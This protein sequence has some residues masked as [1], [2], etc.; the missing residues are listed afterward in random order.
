[1]RYIIALF[2]ALVIGGVVSYVLVS[3]SGDPFNFTH[4]A[5]FSFIIFIAV[6]ILGDVLLA[7]KKEQ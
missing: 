6:V 7:D 1:M 4:S 2:W 3:M 5:I